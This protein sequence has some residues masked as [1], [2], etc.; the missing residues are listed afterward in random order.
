MTMTVTI[1]YKRCFL[2]PLTREFFYDPFKRSDLKPKVVWKKIYN[3]IVTNLLPARTGINL[4]LSS[5]IFDIKLLHGPLLFHLKVSLIISPLPCTLSGQPYLINFSSLPLQHPRDYLSF[6]TLETGPEAHFP[7]PQRFQRWRLWDPTYAF[8]SL[9]TVS[10][11]SIPS[12]CLIKIFK[13]R[14]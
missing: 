13:S 12:G 4:P 10:L 6:P 3:A 2:R 11:P 14:A 9:I 5:A 8:T 7:I 1:S